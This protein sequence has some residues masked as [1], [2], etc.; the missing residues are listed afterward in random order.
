MPLTCDQMLTHVH[1]PLETTREPSS[2]ATLSTYHV[3]WRELREWTD[4]ASS[5]QDYWARLSDADKGRIVPQAPK[6]YWELLS[7]SLTTAVPSY[8]RENHLLMPLTFN[9]AIPHNHA[10]S[11]A[12]DTHARIS[13]TLP[14]SVVG[15]P[16]GCFEQ[17][18]EVRGIIELK[19][20][21]N[22]TNDSIRQ[23]IQGMSL[24]SPSECR[25]F[26][27]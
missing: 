16:D 15:Q 22:L 19:T 23:V 1:A 8:F 11:G 5:A 25:R 21:W 3:R 14:L 9:Y 26:P 17:D 10:I 20:F 27:I 7:D 13:T 18:D 2:S 6:N 24:L 12:C 4:F